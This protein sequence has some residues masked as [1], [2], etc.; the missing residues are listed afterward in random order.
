VTPP[1]IDPSPATSIP[2]GTTTKLPLQ[3]ATSN[4]VRYVFAIY[5]GDNR[6]YYNAV[7]LT[8][9]A[10]WVGWKPIPNQSYSTNQAMN[11]QITPSGSFNISA[12]VGELK[13]FY[14]I[15]ATCS[16]GACSFSPWR[17]GQK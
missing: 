4:G 2:P 11:L 12:Y 14:S 17:A 9:K 15:T 16:N 7:P 3:N 8:G 5:S 10:I 13:S 1:P 6:I